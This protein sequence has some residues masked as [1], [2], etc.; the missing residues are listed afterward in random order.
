M[1]QSVMK[2]ADKLPKRNSIMLSRS[3][4][5]TEHLIT[6]YL[7]T[8]TFIS[9]HILPWFILKDVS[10]N[11]FGLNYSPRCFIKVLGPAVGRRGRCTPE[12]RGS[13]LAPRLLI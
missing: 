2:L 8:M 11:F 3:L 10:A 5:I 12:A 1:K 7:S 13:R 9:Y 6:A 4:L